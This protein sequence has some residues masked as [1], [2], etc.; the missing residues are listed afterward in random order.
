MVIKQNRVLMAGMFAAILG[1]VAILGAVRSDAQLTT[2]TVQGT[3]RD[4][5]NSVVPGVAI[6]VRN[7]ETGVSRSVM[8]DAAGRYVAPN[9]DLGSYEIR[10]EMTGFQTAVRSGLTLTLGAVLQV[11]LT[12]RVGAVSEQVEVTGEAPLVETTQSSV[13]ALVSGNQISDLPLNTRSYTELATLQEGVVQFR[14]SGG[15]STGYGSQLSFAGSR[16]D[17]NAYLLDGADINNV[18][19]KVP[20][21]ASGGVIGVEAIREFQVLTNTYSAQYGK[22]MG[23]QLN[24]V[25]KSGTNTMHGSAYEYLRN[26]KLDARKFF[27][28]G[29]KP[30]KRN[31]FGASLGGPIMHDKLF[32]FGNYEGFRERLGGTLRTLVPDENARL[33][34]LP[35]GPVAGGLNAVTQRYLNNLDLFPLP[36]PDGRR[37][38]DGTAESVSTVTQPVYEDYFLGRADYY[39]SEKDSIFGRYAHSNSD[40]LFSNRPASRI[41]LV[42]PNR[43]ATLQDTHIFSPVWLNTIRVS[44]NRSSNNVPNPILVEIPKELWFNDLMDSLFPGNQQFGNINVTGISGV[45]GD[46]FSPRFLTLNIWEVGDDVNYTSG[47]HSLKF[48]ALYKRIQYNVKGALEPRGVYFV[49]NLSNFLRGIPREFRS[50][51]PGSDGVRGLRQNYLGLYVQDDYQMRPGL[52]LNLGVRWEFV[53]S[54]AEVNGKLANLDDLMSSAIR[55]GEP[56]YDNNSPKNLSPRVGFAWDPFGKGTTSLKGGYGIF[57]DQI[58][59]NA[60]SLPVFRTPPFMRQANITAT[61][62]P[63]GVVPWPNAFD[64][65]RTAT[66][67]DLNV[68]SIKRDSQPPYMQQWNLSLEH[69]IWGGTSVRAGYIGSRGLHLG[70]LIDNIAYSV[71]TPEGRFVPLTLNGAAN[72]GVRRNTNFAEIRQRTFDVNSYYHGLVLSLKR[73]L[74]NGLQAQ[75]SYT[76]SKSVDDGSNFLGQGETNQNSQWGLLPEDPSF[77]R[78]LSA[79]NVRNNFSVNTTYELPIGKGKTFGNNWTGAVEMI[80]G[81][82][83]INNIL[84]LQGGVPFTAEV[85]FDRAG[86]ARTNGQAVRPNL[87][88][89]A[90]N[91]PTSG[92]SAGCRNSDGTVAVVAGTPLGTPDLWFDPCAFAVP[93]VGYLGNLARNTIIGP[94]LINWDVSFSKNFRAPSVA[95]KFNV[96]FRAELFNITNRVNLGEVSRTIFNATPSYLGNAGRFTNTADARQVQF[97]LKVTW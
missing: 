75:V 33:G 28:S 65:V 83:G 86:E 20:A 77:D 6:T 24:A 16:P 10:S 43:F 93:Q 12:L 78:G 1:I 13:A 92:V 71:D 7:V 54:P 58:I 18:Y 96:Q 97:G 87:A 80:L 91:N 68:Q 21:S 74:R 50:Q 25:T 37:F 22:S 59:Y 95:E 66:A 52:T 27:D 73:R 31:Q 40:V 36:T 72:R 70:R 39:L 32:F 4:E 2:G 15:T 14:N 82:W 67:F 34:I 63:G 29:K 8:T 57:F 51:V 89:G 48:G 56:Y 30:F 69:E 94:G 81:G 41:G 23:G 85:G 19:N 11:D 64:L 17:A 44:F 9:L 61:N 47:G 5:Q 46:R 38:A 3:V 79:F 35:S 55:V 26:D 84:K 45:G 62:A 49:S 90:S 76:F 53:T 42:V 60:Y 88:P